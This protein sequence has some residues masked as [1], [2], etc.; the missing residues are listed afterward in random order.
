MLKKVGLCIVYRNHNYGGILQS[1]ATLMKMDELGIDYEIIDYQHPSNFEYF[2]NAFPSLINK[3]TIYSK[4]RSFRKKVVKRFHSQYRKNESIRNEKFTSFI[5]ERFTKVSKPIRDYSDLRDYAERF[6]DIIVGS[7]Q[8]WLPSGLGTGFYNLMFAPDN[9]NKIAYASSF[10]VSTI[11][12]NQIE[13]TKEYLSRINYIS[14]R[15]ES[16]QKIIKQLTGREVPVILDPT[17]IVSK[18]QWDEC[19]PNR[20]IVKGDYIFCY[21]LGN[22]PNQRAEVKRLS[23]ET[24]LKIVTLRHIDE[25][26]RSDETFGDIGLYDVGPEEFINLIRHAKYICTDSFHGSVFSIIYHKQFISFNR[27]ADGANS[28]NSRLETLFHNIGISRRF[29]IDIIQEM[30]APIDYD[31]VDSRLSLLRSASHKYIVEALNLNTKQDNTIIKKG[32]QT[33]KHMICSEVECTGCSVCSAVCPQ[34]A[35]SMVMDNC[36]FWRPEVDMSLCIKC[37][38]C[39]RICPVNQVPQTYGPTKAF[40]YQNSDDNIRF[41]STSGGFFNTV[42]TKILNEKGVVCGAAFDEEMHLSH[43]F[44]ECVEGLAQLQKSKYV[45]SSLSGVFKK[46]KD[47]LK[48]GREVLFVGVGCQAAALRKYIGENDKLIIIDLVCYGVPSTGL[49]NDWINYLN[50]KYG[51]V[52][53]VRFRDKTYGYA[54]P[55]VKVLFEGDKYIEACRDS[56]MYTDLFFRH[57][58]IRKCCHSCHFKTVNRASD[59]TLGDLWLIGKYNSTQDDNKGTTAAFAHTEKGKELCKMICQMEIN[60]D[61]VVNAD[62]LKLVESVEKVPYVESFWKKYQEDGFVKTVNL[63][64]SNSLKNKIKYI[65]KKVMNA[66]GF[67]R[68]WYRRQ[69]ERTLIKD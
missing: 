30:L 67:S 10:G 68:V 17:M 54:T 27:F 12:K 63:Y 11:P 9:C 26:I 31:K 22:N 19:I 53:D 66:T 60:V 13:K 62:A 69:K 29:K 64:E 24:N 33:R 44:V 38:A 45:Q 5:C 36:G 58:S 6:S 50:Q 3:V 37:N 21:F 1:Y 43:T 65:I 41:N 34:N 46:I 32:E 59:I 16:G 25:F 18:E 56:N 28:R 51:K 42:A 61:S 49:F 40:A 4:F 35:I 7:D 48:D 14:V 39:S 57:L 55:N 15:E 2:K 47:Y 23:Q 8:M 52:E 20:M